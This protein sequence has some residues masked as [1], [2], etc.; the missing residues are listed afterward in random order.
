MACCLADL[1]MIPLCQSFIEKTGLDQGEMFYPLR[2]NVCMHCYYVGLP[3]YV[4]P[5]EIFS[6]Y[7]Y[8]SSV[9]SSWIEYVRSSV[10]SLVAEFGLSYATQVIEMGSNDGYLLQFFVEKGIPALGIEP[11]ENVA[12]VANERGIPTLTAFFNRQTAEELRKRSK[13]ADLLLSYNCL[14]HVPDLND[15]VAGMKL[16][17]NP[18]GIIQIE[19]PYLDSLV[20]SNQFDTIYHDR[21]SYL[22]F[23]AAGH[24]F[25]RNGLRIFDVMRI[26]TH[27]GSLRLRACHSEN[28]ARPTLP[29]VATL[30]A[31]ETDRGMKTPGYYS[32]FMEQVAATKRNL[33]DFLIRQKRDGRSIVGYGAPAK[34]NVL[35]NYCG[36]GADFIDY[37]VDRNPYKRGKYA[38]GTRLPVR[39]V[40]EVRLTRPDFLL[41]LP[42]NIKDEIISQMSC[43]RDWGGRFLVPI[44][45]VDVI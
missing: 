41:I 14:D 23:L 40:E 43:I 35:L 12:K 31:D 3:V 19:I 33:L 37:L 20:E 44:P 6:E 4:S 36:I 21:F 29:S 38:P 25:D 9:S 17:L 1:G 16:L 2:A 18:Q 28:K 30:R 7:A 42:W 32:R 22:S 8:F 11:A 34:G 5:Q 45:A 10:E 27:G 13:S 26:P 15:V 39:D 24:L